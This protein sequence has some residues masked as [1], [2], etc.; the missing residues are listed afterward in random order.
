MI[1]PSRYEDD[2]VLDYAFFDSS[3]AREFADVAASH[4]ADCRIAD[5][6]VGG[7]VATIPD[8][9]AE[10]VLD[11]LDDCYER[12]QQEQAVRATAEEGWVTKRIAGVQ[13]VV[14][15]GSLRTVR[16]DADIANRLLAAFT[17]EE[18]QALVQAIVRNLENPSEGPLCKTLPP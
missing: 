12:L 17:P 13:V 4:G 1:V 7:W 15:D 6:P 16:L 10:S 2:A 11:A 3:L 18:A 9:L 14:A 5:D 8:N